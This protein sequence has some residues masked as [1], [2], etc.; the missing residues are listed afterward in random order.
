MDQDELERLR[1]EARRRELI[2]E[3]GQYLI[4]M[5]EAILGVLIVWVAVIIVTTLR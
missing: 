5:A 3:M 2:Y 1:R 4:L